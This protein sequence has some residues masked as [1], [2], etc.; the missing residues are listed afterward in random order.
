MTQARPHTTAL[1]TDSTCDIPSSLVAEYDIEVLPAYVIWGDEQY[2]DRID[3]KATEFYR[4][5]DSDPVYPTSAHPTPGD[6]L[7]AYTA[8]SARGAQ[9]IVVVTVSSAMSGTYG[10]AKQAAA[11]VE[12]PVHVVDSRGPTMSLGWQVLAAA[13]AR[14]RGAG[15]EEMIAAAEAVRGQMAQLVYMDAIKYL[16]KGGRIGN[17]VSLV[18]TVLR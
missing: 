1:I 16:E 13:R 15:A 14:A 10:A 11:Q 17:A 6:F 4:R 5:L 8:A 9:D 7:T 12:I 3:M 18:G 2:R